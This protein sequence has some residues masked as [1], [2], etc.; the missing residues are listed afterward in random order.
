M[1]DN[2]GKTYGNNRRVVAYPKP[3]YFML[4][5]ADSANEGVSKSYIIAKIVEK[6]YDGLPIATVDKLKVV[7]NNLDENEK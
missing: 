6:Y 1:A 3:K 5:A 7:Y 2:Y 4:I